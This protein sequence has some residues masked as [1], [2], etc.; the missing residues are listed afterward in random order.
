ML[1]DKLEHELVLMLTSFPDTFIEAADF[2][3]PNSIVD[4]ANG[5]AD[6][7]NTFYNALPV[8]KAETPEI[9]QA[10][11]ALVDAVRIVLRNSLALIGIK[12]PEKM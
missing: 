7:F 1:K 10:R 8:I 6:R 9:S 12:A 4:S 11:L 3:K 5:L 2:L